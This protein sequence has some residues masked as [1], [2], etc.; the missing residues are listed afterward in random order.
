MKVH[1]FLKTPLFAAV[2][3]S[4]KKVDRGI[5]QLQGTLTR[6]EDGCL[7]LEDL[8]FSDGEGKERQAPFRQLSLPLH[9][10]DYYL[11][12]EALQ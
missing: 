3:S 4:G 7:H 5:L 12:L 8:S 10:V 6:A 9:K 2:L 11:P 1:I